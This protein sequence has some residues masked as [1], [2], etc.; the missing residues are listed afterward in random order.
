MTPTLEH[1]YY[2]HKH[3]VGTHVEH[4]GDGWRDG[5]IKSKNGDGTYEV[6]FKNVK[7]DEIRASSD[8]RASSSSDNIAG[9]VGDRPAQQ[10]SSSN[11]NGDLSSSSDVGGDVD[12][13]SNGAS[14]SSSSGGD[15][16]GIGDT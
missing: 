5:V 6:V 8:V 13:S 4:T 16:V 11:S 1:R 9:V 10:T 14:A 12:R 2:P 15:V 3:D 7:E